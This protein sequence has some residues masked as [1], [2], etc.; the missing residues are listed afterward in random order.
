MS[1]EE[2]GLYYASP[3]RIARMCEAFQAGWSKRERNNRVV[4]SGRLEVDVA[5]HQAETPNRKPKG[6]DIPT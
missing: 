4:A 6:S 1:D 3:E 5:R 2:E